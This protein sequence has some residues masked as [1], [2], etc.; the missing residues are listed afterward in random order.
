MSEI[1]I[2]TAKLE[3]YISSL[4][5][6]KSYLESEKSNYS[7]V[8]VSGGG[9]SVEKLAEVDKYFSTIRSSM[10]TMISNSVTFFTNVENSMVEADEEAA[11]KMD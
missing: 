3:K 4:K 7:Q 2:N 6:Q 9:Q 1:K 5:R 10:L 8:S 11:S